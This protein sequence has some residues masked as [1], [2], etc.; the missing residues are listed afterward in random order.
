MPLIIFPSYIFENIFP[1]CQDEPECGTLRLSSL[2]P[3]PGSVAELHLA[4]TNTFAH[5]FVMKMDWLLARGL[6]CL[7]L[8]RTWSL[9]RLHIRSGQYTLLTHHTHSTIGNCVVC[10]RSQQ[11]ACDWSSC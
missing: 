3:A 1:A 4:L 10:V 11:Q 8:A 7:G 9:T 2:S 5:L 6:P